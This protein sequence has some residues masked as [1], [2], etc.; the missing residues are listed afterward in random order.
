MRLKPILIV[1]LAAAL[2][3]AAAAQSDSPSTSEATATHTWRPS[4]GLPL[5]PMGLSLPS[6]GLPLPPTGLPLPRTGFPATDTRPHTG[7]LDGPAEINRQHRGSG[8][9]GILHSARTFVYLMP[10]YAFGY[11]VGYPYWPLVG[12]PAPIYDPQ[13]KPRDQKLAT[14]R[15]RLELQPNRALQLYVDGY[16][17][18]TP[19]DFSGELELDPGPH[20][21]QVR[22]PGFETLQFEVK[23]L[24][25]RSITYRGMLKSEDAK[26]APAPEPPSPT[27]VRPSGPTTFYV[28]PGCY[29]GNVPPKDVKLP[30]TCDE[31]RLVTFE[32]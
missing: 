18:G 7:A 8:R 27:Y 24:S 4:I 11:G 14:G 20:T 12:T 15:L 30:V 13:S 26:P 3:A 6:M 1:A 29:A 31:S 2:P 17:V 21:I 19:E 10:S 32:Q 28:I 22:A 25:G 23:I 5:P 9:D 16:Y